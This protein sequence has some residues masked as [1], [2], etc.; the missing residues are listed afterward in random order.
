LNLLQP[1]SV[2]SAAVL[3]VVGDAFP[4]RTTRTAR[5]DRRRVY[6]AAA[7]LIATFGAVLVVSNA[8][9]RMPLPF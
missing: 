7:C 4:A 6:L 2:T 1:V 8:G 3:G 5:R 9:W